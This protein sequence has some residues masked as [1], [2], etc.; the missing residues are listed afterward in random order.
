MLILNDINLLDYL[1]Y[2][3]LNME[4]FYLIHRQMNLMHILNVLLDNAYNI[5]I[6]YKIQ[7]NLIQYMHQGW[8]Y[9]ILHQLVLLNLQQYQIFY[10][11]TFLTFYINLLFISKFCRRSRIMIERLGKVYPA[12]QRP[13]RTLLFLGLTHGSPPS[14]PSRHEPR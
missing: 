14:A 8:L 11:L 12:G 13:F 7:L 5:L 2:H 6:C 3:L 1:L 10:Y 9:Y 4:L